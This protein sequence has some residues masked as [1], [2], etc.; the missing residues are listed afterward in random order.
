M[1]GVMRTTA[2]QM[3]KLR[4]GYVSVPITQKARMGA[5]ESWLGME[6]GGGGER[7]PW[8]PHPQAKAAM[9]GTTLPPQPPPPPVSNECY[10]LLKSQL[11]PSPYGPQPW[12]GGG[13]IGEMTANVGYL[14]GPWLE[15]LCVARARAVVLGVSPAR[16]D[17]GHD[18]MDLADRHQS[19]LST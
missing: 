13:G 1:A 14:E 6:M 11:S 10:L 3:G 4:L 16:L 19:A 9:R 7:E 12:C 17:L 18:R 15:L 2:L 8:S 5:Q